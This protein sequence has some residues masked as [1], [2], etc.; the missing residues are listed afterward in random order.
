ML[1][2]TLWSIVFMY[3]HGMYNAHTRFIL[4][5]VSKLDECI[6]WYIFIWY[7]FIWY[8]TMT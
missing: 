5:A 2:H 8:V 1:W 4:L 6:I 3:G 7:I